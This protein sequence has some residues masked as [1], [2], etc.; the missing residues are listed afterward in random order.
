[1]TK[2]AIAER[3]GVPEQ[4]GLRNCGW[5]NQMRYQYGSAALVKSKSPLASANSEKGKALRRICQTQN[6]RVIGYS[7]EVTAASTTVALL[8]H[9]IEKAIEIVAWLISLF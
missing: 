4:T 8:L 6:R 3:A 7:V 9:A 2:I 1:M 5:A